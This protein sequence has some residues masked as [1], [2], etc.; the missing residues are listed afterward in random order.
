MRDV[1]LL[2]VNASELLTLAGPER[3]RAGLEMRDNAAVP[4]G[5]AALDGGVVIETGDSADLL[6][7]YRG[8]RTVDAA[9]RLAMPGFTDPHTHL[10]FAGSRENEMSL[11]LSGA[12]YLDILKKGGGIHGTVAATRNASLDA[13]LE[14]SRRRTAQV[15]AH[16]TTMVEIKSGYGLDSPTEEKILDVIGL[17]KREGPP[18]VIATF[19]GAHT[20]PSSVKREDYLDWLLREAMPRFKE[21]AEFCDV[22]CEDGAFTPEESERILRSAKESGYKLKIHAGQFNDL[23]AAGMAASLGAVSA[24]HCDRVSP[25]QMDLMR[26]KGTVAVLLPGTSFFLGTDVYPDFQKFNEHG[27]A[28]ALATDF[29][30]GSCPCF[31]MQMMIGLAVHRMGMTAQ[32]AVTAS[33]VNA[34]WAVDRGK[35]AG[36]LEPGKQADLIVLDVQN[37]AQIPYYFGVNLVKT[38]VKGGRVVV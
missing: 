34:A 25:H 13:L 20:I 26:E 33:T 5:A 4:N 8:R 2:V 38:V 35:Q 15:L 28:V 37:A 21:K 19:L 9:G 27:V 10:V 18:D 22:F 11:R 14:L 7:K 23:G 29:N 16:G 31:S 30:P 3:P 12:T 1:D 36:S 32:E 6:R 24:D 17:L